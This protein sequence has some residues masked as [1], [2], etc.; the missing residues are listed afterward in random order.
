MNR[1]EGFYWIRYCGYWVVAEWRRIKTHYWW[2]IP[3]NDVAYNSTHE[4]KDIIVNENR[5]PEPEK[6]AGKDDLS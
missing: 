5:L 3:G 4:G 6:E 2:F 1:Q